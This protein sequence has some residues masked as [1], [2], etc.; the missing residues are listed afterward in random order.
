MEE[1]R[2]MTMGAGPRAD[3]LLTECGVVA[4]NVNSA[5]RDRHRVEGLWPSDI[6]FFIPKLNALRD[7]C[8]A[9]GPMSCIA[10]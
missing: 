2:T 10:R 4:P 5:L 9:A 8:E 7:R 6:V 3:S 1:K